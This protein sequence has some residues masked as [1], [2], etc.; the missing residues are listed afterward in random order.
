ML[1]IAKVI[2]H[3]SNKGDVFAWKR[4][5]DLGTPNKASEQHQSG[6][7]RIPK[8]RVMIPLIPFSY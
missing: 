8:Q 1:D 3:G 7:R 6:A 4:N 5:S 2:T